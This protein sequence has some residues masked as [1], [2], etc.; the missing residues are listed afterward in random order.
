M[1]VS[2]VS[3]DPPVEV[4]EPIEHEAQKPKKKT[5]HSIHLTDRR[6]IA[7]AIAVMMMMMMMMMTMTTTMMSSTRP[8]WK[9]YRHALCLVPCALCARAAVVLCTGAR[10]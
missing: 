8:R 1:G 2:G 7:I 5:L 9:R 4:K 6:V 3:R 10:A